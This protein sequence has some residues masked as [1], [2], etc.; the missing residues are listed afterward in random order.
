M[1]DSLFLDSNA[2]MDWADTIDDKDE[3]MLADDDP[4]WQRR[5]VARNRQIQIGKAR[6]EYRRYLSEMPKANRS[7]SQPL[8]PDPRAR[9]SKRQFD[10]ALG[11]WRRRLHDY[12]S[13]P[14]HN[15]SGSGSGS[16]GSGRGKHQVGLPA[17]PPLPGG[18][19]GAQP[20]DDGS[21]KR[22]SRRRQRK[23]AQEKRDAAAALAASDT[24]TQVAAEIRNTLGIT[25]APEHQKQTQRAGAPHEVG[26]AAGLGSG[27]HVLRLAD[28]L[29]EHATA[30]PALGNAPQMM[31]QM[32]MPYDQGQ[33]N[34]AQLNQAY[35]NFNPFADIWS[36]Q[37]AGSMPSMAFPQQPAPDAMT[38]SMACPSVFDFTLAQLQAAQQPMH[39]SL[40]QQQQQSYCSSSPTVAM[41]QLALTP[42]S[43]EVAEPPGG[44]FR[45]TDAEVD[46][47]LGQRRRSSDEI[48]SYQDTPEPCSFAQRDPLRG[49][50]PVDDEDLTPQKPTHRVAPAVR[51]AE[52]AAA[53][54]KLQ[55]E[56][57][58]W[59]PRLPSPPPLPR[60][61]SAPH[62]PRV[63][64]RVEADCMSPNPG[65]SS[66][67]V[68]GTPSRLP[69]T[70]LPKTPMLAGLGLCP[71]T[72]SP[73][74]AWFCLDQVHKHQLS[75]SAPSQYNTTPGFPTVEE[76]LAVYLSQQQQQP[77]PQ[78]Q[79]GYPPAPDAGE[80]WL[81]NAMLC[82]NYHQQAAQAAQMM[83]NM[84]Q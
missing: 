65:S 56:K 39:Q 8:T 26:D 13:S 33:L 83:Q 41:P 15:S 46:S 1:A 58:V 23:L 3:Q 82:L 10:R 22:L 59:A 43:A 67:F 21:P 12:D 75:T 47:T 49:G 27:V 34:Q 18:E 7:P 24:R 25:S 32:Q 28:S 80:A 55:K 2:T 42:P 52:A 38:A 62:T 68:Q 51:A 40:Q 77:Q 17:A 45:A 48:M 76:Q 53:V 57:Q 29:A 11:E 69:C 63:I 64:K 44:E 66:R 5:E 9:V 54:E 20:S 14:W 50:S 60:S 61:V 35:N 71:R 73:D 79:A 36:Q 4:A 81:R 6:P 84:S 16:E 31:T 37:F 78:V 72:P 70:P 19:C 30:A 74:R